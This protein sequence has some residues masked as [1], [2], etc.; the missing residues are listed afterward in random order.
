M[1]VV[2]HKLPSTCALLLVLA[3]SAC[4]PIDLD[5]GA[6]AAPFSLAKACGRAE[7]DAG[8]DACGD[9][10]APCDFVAHAAAPDAE[11]LDACA[12]YVGALGICVGEALDTDCVELASVERYAQTDAYRC[13][14]DLGCDAIPTGAGCALP[15]DDA[16]LADQLCAAA[17]ACGAPCA[18]AERQT[19]A[20]RGAWARD[21]VRAAL[22]ACASEPCEDVSRCIGA[23]VEAVDGRPNRR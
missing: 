4:R 1:R 16:A 14:A 7:C 5:P 9:A 17:E 8:L 19:I 23:W 3:G 22:V 12:A 13:L 2:M 15:A 10:T 11:L 20:E 6:P 21:D 18:E